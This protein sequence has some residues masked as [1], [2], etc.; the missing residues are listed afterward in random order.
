M[1]YLYD[2][3][4]KLNKRSQRYMVYLITYR[5]L[6]ISIKKFLRSIYWLEEW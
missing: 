6:T 4:E 2:Y 5:Y 1:G 3:Y